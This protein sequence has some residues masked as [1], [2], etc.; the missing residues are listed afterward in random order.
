MKKILDTYGKAFGQKINFQKLEV[1]F[2]ANTH[3]FLRQNIFYNIGISKSIGTSRYL[4]LP[5]VIGKKK[6]IF[7]FIKERLWK[8]INHYSKHLSKAGKEMLVKLVAQYIPSYYMSVFLLLAAL[9][10]EL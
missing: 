3:P 4:G 8:C 2:S 1:F 5:S 10:D 7:G 9:E 6:Q